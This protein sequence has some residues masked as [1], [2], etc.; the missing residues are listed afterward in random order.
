MNKILLF[1]AAVLLTAQLQAQI[2]WTG[3]ISTDW[4]TDGNW[5]T[6]QVPTA[7][8]D[9]IIATA[10]NQ[11]VI[12][13]AG[14]LAK[15]VEV[16]SGAVLT[17]QSAGTLTVNGS[18]SI[19]GIT[20]FYN[21]GTVENSGQLLIGNVSDVGNYGLFNYA[22]FTNNTG[23]Q[24]SIDR[25]GSV[26]L[27]NYNGT[28][29]NAGALSI[30][31]T[32]DVGNYGLFNGATFNNN[33]GGQISIDRCSSEGLENVTGPFGGTFNNAATIT[34]GAHASVGYGII[35]QGTFN[36]N[37]GGQIN[38][39]SC[40][41]EGLYNQ[42]GTFNNAATITIGANAS[43]GDIGLYVYTS[44][45]F[46]NNTGGQ[47]SID[48]SINRGLL[49]NTGGIFTNAA[50]IIIGA[51]AS[52]GSL[53]LLNF[54]TFNNNTGGQISIDRC[55]SEGLQNGGTFINAANITIGANAGV[56]S[57]GLV[58]NS[59][60]SFTN[61]DCATLSLFAPVYNQNSNLSNQGLMSVSTTGTHSN[62]GFTNSGVLVFPLGNPIPNVSNGGIIASPLSGCG[63]QITPALQLGSSNPFT[64]GSTWF[65]NV[66]LSQSA[67]T[68]SNNTFTASGLNTGTTAVYFTVSNGNCTQTVSLP[69]TVTNPVGDPAVFGNG[70]WNVYAWNAG[71]ASN[72]N[73]QSWNANYSGYYTD[74]AVSFDTRNKWDSL[75]SPSAAQG[76]QGCPVGVDNHSWSA[77]RQG[78]DCGY[79]QISI[80][81]HDDGAQLYINGELIWQHIDGCCDV[82][83][84]IW[85]GFLKADS[86]VEFRGTEG[87]EASY[88]NITVTNITLAITANGPTT[89]CSG[90]VTLN[91]N[92]ATGNQWFRN[93]V[94]IDGATAQTHIATVSGN[95]TVRLTTD[96][97]TLTSEPITVTTPPGDPAVFGNNGWN[98]YA[99]NAGGAT[100][101]TNAW[102]TNY[103]GY[104]ADTSFKFDTRWNAN[105]SPS[106]ASGYQG[107]TVNNDNHSW[108]AKRKGFPCGH[109]RISIPG[110]DDAAQ[111]FINGDSVW[112]H[113]GCCDSHDNIWEGDLGADSKVEFRGTEGTQ[114]SYGAITFT[115]ITPAI[116]ADGPTTVCAGSVVLSSSFVTGNQWYKS[117]VLI[118]GATN[119]TYSAT[120]TGSYFVQVNSLCGNQTSDAIN[121]TVTNPT[122]GDPAVF[123]NGIWN[124]YAWNA[125][126]AS[127]SNNQSWN[128]NY[129][130]YYTD[131][132]VNF[133]TRNKWDSLLSPSAAQGYQGCL[134]GV[135]NHSWSAKRHG[136]DCGYYQISIP[137][138]D[139]GAQLYIN[140]KLE[141]QHINGCC[142][143]HANVWE[144]YL[145]ADSKIE[146]RG[147]EGQ[148]SSYG[149]L[150]ISLI[151]PVITAGSSPTV[152][153]GH[154]LVLTASVTGSDLLWSTGE[155]TQSITVTQPGVY[156]VKETD[157]C[158]T[159]IESLPFTVN[160]LVAPGTNPSGSVIVS[161]CKGYVTLSPTGYSNPAQGYSFTWYKVGT[162]NP[163][164]N[165]FSFNVSTEG[166]YYVVVSGNGCLSPPSSTV[167]VTAGSDPSSIFGNN[168]WIVHTF[169]DENED[170]DYPYYVYYG[171]Y[172]DTTLSF[173]SQN[174]WPVEGSPSY[175][176]GYTGCWV[177]EDFFR[178]SAKR[179][180]FPCGHYKINIPGHDDWMELWVNGVNVF[181][182]R[183]CCD[184]HPDVW[185]GDLGPS[186]TIEFKVTEFY[187]DAYGAI[188]LELMSA[189]ITKPT[190]TPSGS[191]NICSGDII[192]LTSSAATGNTWSTG[193]TTQ[194]IT[195]NTA[196]N[197]S[198]TVTG[199]AGCTAQSDT[200]NITVH[201]QQIWYRDADGDGYGN[202]AISITA[203][204]V[205]VGY[206]ANNT[207]CNDRKATVYPG[208][209]ELC[210]GL[211]NNCNGQIDEG[212][213]TPWYRDADGDGYGN[214]ALSIIACKRPAGYVANK[215]DCDDN[216]NTVY[217]GAPELCDGKDNNCNGTIDERC[218]LAAVSI[219]DVSIIEGNRGNTNMMFTISLSA[220]ATKKITVQ[221]ATQDST[222]IAGS[223]YNARSGTVTFTA[224]ITQRTLSISIIGD[225]T[226]EPGETFKVNLSN[227]FNATI[228]KAT[229]TGTII[230]DDG[231]AFA[232]AVLE[233]G[234]T[235]SRSVKIAPNPVKSL[236]NIELSG[237][238]GNVTLQLI[239]IQGRV[240]R[241]EK[242]QPVKN[243]AKQQMTVEGIASGT[244]LLI[245]M[246]EKGNR[247]REKVI[248]ER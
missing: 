172:S 177:Y 148:Q 188:D 96:G 145:N 75:L 93:G 183:G 84:N 90:S 6:G 68:Y 202:P 8:D 121:V 236:L 114:A 21:S 245:V 168:V 47:I 38:I 42:G 60:G 204:T 55:S 43:V 239:S 128:A 158:G 59:S 91:S 203:C 182:H 1:V 197:Y 139:D 191:V 31:A 130:G 237:Y 82:H 167:H 125:G 11:T 199:S 224:G 119:Q 64:I 25:S 186:S 83:P 232:S 61:S 144:G 173:N 233:T 124:V 92:I 74:S 62:A 150:D 44:S 3:T 143:A 113:D 129:S 235:E 22:T 142:D 34:I 192:T 136:F 28:F 122:G 99:W 94:P 138:H 141:W 222:A 226:T 201:P 156:T 198:V 161:T 65:S 110:H 24:I 4:N 103:A 185:E 200:V 39:D 16:K 241:Q 160:G 76:Y 244:Y 37:T 193:D 104:Y 221:F 234:I 175:A 45:S 180:G 98:V 15:T 140:G 112:Q 211:D 53:G 212:V 171:N 107:C 209:P 132:A 152:C 187:G 169:Q 5:S 50:T 58:N 115:N 135:D 149:A 109:Y 51:N 216:D 157:T 67:G 77:K 153:S 159:Q 33:T 238:S 210:D 154:P 12:S 178:F 131:S 66:A 184:E 174:E 17:I 217:P 215:R 228:A 13:T 246:D 133:D 32:A 36:N 127:N 111:L 71:D 120:V 29:T 105:T 80:L 170:P 101:N 85:Q 196:G 205:P 240:L 9:V 26:G 73:A 46:N 69:V 100:I 220:A 18:K 230:N 134:V 207:D 194:S 63:S 181:E 123:G 81:G 57:L 52:V 231:A 137:G 179:K 218:P 87:T 40:L 108:S 97:C 70:I 106:S 56:G 95:Y 247:Q 102:N 27:Y 164:G 223:D 206:V 79:Y 54:A 48:R 146:F 23:G 163:V 88:G 89:L 116:T 41:D 86:K 243:Y 189:D 2:T 190:I 229:G 35:N 30:G 155:T 14:A 248:I 214:A 20:A 219:N 162:A 165:T 208:A 10:T 195:V 213:G 78:F 176:T 166:D 151:K 225:K 126:D 49:I 118:P 227:P 242:I 117:N 7:S 19:N 147:T 72:S